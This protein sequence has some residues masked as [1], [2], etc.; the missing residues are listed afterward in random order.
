MSGTRTVLVVD[1][2][3]DV[4]DALRRALRD[5]DRE[6]LGC[7][8]PADAL[9]ILAR[10]PV[11]LVIADLDMPE[12][13]GLELLRRI[14]R[15]HPDATRIVLTGR[16]D[17]DSALEAI[18]HGEVHRYLTKPW[19]LV[20][21]RQTVDACLE[22]LEES[23]RAA[24]AARRASLRMALREQLELQHPGITR[25]ELEEGAVPLDPGRIDAAWTF[26][27]PVA[28]APD[29]HWRNVAQNGMA[30]VP[31]HLEALS[32][33]TLERR[34]RLEEPIGSGGF[35]VVYRAV[36]LSLERRVAVKLLRA[37]A[38]EGTHL[39]RFRIEALSSCRVVH[40]NA[41]TVLD[42]GVGDGGLAY[43]VME[44]LSGETL[45]QRLRRGETLPFD[46]GARIAGDVC[47]ALAVA[48]ASGI[49]HRDVKPANVF[50]HRGPEGPVTKLLDFGIATLASAR[51]ASTH[52]HLLGTPAYI[53]PERVAGRA[54][55][56]RAD[57]YSVGVLLYEVLCGA[58]PLEAPSPFELS[59]QHLVVHPRP[60]HAIDPSV[61]A[62]LDQ[63]VARML[64]KDPAERPTAAE[65]AAS[66]R[67]LASWL[68]AAHMRRASLAASLATRSER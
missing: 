66:L 43:L 65:A 7:T 31:P 14:R 46:E 36:Q 16:P 28:T 42:A 3:R 39:E 19:Q 10:R 53:A 5:A 55:D 6:V 37:S 60:L 50:L 49:V 47:A 30:L 40:P 2:E 62:P 48:H 18:N 67:D 38:A 29:V 11:D 68:P 9:E 15:D 35:G 45:S 56:G 61:P 34:F 41:V 51:A 24:D 23:R 58:R 44:L 32:G 59:R 25:V 57:V 4:V 52:G 54:A 63:L 20:A 8:R 12:M 1:D 26:R 17:L 22:R 64:A 13:H 21:L 33:T 27:D